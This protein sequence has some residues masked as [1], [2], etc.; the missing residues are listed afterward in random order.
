MKFDAISVN[1]T[2]KKVTTASSSANVAMPTMADGTNARYVRCSATATCYVKPVTT[3]SGT[4]ANT[5]VMVTPYESVILNV[6]GF[7]FLA[8]IYDSAAGTLNVVPIEA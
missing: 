8:Y 6:R 7:D 2:G 3:N 4:A 5:D 1:G